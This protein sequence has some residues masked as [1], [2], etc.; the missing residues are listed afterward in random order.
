MSMSSIKE[1]K[2]QQQKPPQKLK[3]AQK[4]TNI[5]FHVFS[6]Q[7]QKSNVCFFF[8]SYYGIFLSHQVRSS[9]K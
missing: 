1:K 8:L 4:Q 6:R 3:Q 5:L 9:Y 7:P 2:K